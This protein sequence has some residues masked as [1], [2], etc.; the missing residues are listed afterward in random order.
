MQLLK[1]SFDYAKVTHFAGITF[2]TNFARFTY[3]AS[4]T[5]FTTFTCRRV[6]TSPD[7]LVEFSEI[8]DPIIQDYHGI[9][10]GATHKTNLD[11]TKVT[12]NI[13]PLYPAHSVRYV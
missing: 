9:N 4:F 13:K 5:T 11:P 1:T 8:F 7:I 3:V 10:E 6:P 12:S 2:F